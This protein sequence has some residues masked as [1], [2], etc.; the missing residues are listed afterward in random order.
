MIP[1]YKILIVIIVNNRLQ[2]FG[3]VAR[4]DSFDRME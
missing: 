3:L 2:T 4:V 1:L